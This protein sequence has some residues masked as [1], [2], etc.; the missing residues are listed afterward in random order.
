MHQRVGD[1]AD[2]AAEVGPADA[3]ADDDEGGVGRRVENLG[4]GLTDRGTWFDM[5]VGEPVTPRA[6]HL[7]QGGGDGV[8]HL[9]LD[10]RVERW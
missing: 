2:V 5:Y 6:Q 3:S 9:A 1:G 8:G 4:R 7:V 10:T